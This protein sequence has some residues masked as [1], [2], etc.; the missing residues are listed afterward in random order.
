MNA[1]IGHDLAHTV[2]TVQDYALFFY[3]LVPE[4]RYEFLIQCLGNSSSPSRIVWIFFSFHLRF[5]LNVLI[6]F[7]IFV[8][9]ILM[10]LV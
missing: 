7:V 1:F 9:P 2:L 4:I 6:V 3:L 8:C 10:L 5:Y